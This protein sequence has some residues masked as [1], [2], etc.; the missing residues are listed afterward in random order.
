MTRLLTALILCM[1]VA[2]CASAPKSPGALE[3]P[4][5]KNTEYKALETNISSLHEY[6][7]FKD[8]DERLFSPKNV[9]SNR[10][11]FA[12][13]YCTAGTSAGVCEKHFYEAAFSRLSEIY[14]AANPDAVVRTCNNEPIVCDDLV[15]LET[16]FGRLHNASVEQSKQE[17]LSQIENW[18]EGKLT[19]EE[20]KAAL[21]LDFKF[22]NGKLILA[23]PS[24]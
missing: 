24:A 1:S 20:L 19:D 18:R 16:L 11:T 9:D 22:E 10:E 7:V 23:P 6:S 4:E 5:T 13:N 8:A 3:T 15:S 21:H 17:K 2:A 12:Q 14:F